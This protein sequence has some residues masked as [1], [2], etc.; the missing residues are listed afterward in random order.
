MQAGD[1]GLFVAD[2]LAGG[3]RQPQRPKRSVWRLPHGPMAV[4]SGRFPMLSRITGPFQVK[5]YFHWIAQAM[6]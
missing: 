4:S 6:R 3:M 2:V 5:Q 1:H